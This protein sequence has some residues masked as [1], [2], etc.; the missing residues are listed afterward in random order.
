M[1]EK[2]PDMRQSKT[3]ILSTNVDQKL[4]ETEISIAICRPNR[5]ATNGNQNTV[6]SDF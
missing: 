3:L 2:A 5:R 1:T 4:V 6:S